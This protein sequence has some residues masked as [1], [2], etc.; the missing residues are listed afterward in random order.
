MCLAVPGKLVS[1]EGLVGT[2][3]VEGTR[4]LARLDF[5]DEAA[6]GDYLLVHAG[7]A[8]ARVTPEEA[9]ETLQLRREVARAGRHAAQ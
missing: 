6:V 5:M 8:I 1:V 3:D 7:F 9:Q 4:V 2:V